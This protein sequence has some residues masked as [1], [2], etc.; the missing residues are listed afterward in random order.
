MIVYPI[1]FITLLFKGM[2]NGRS[3][4]SEVGREVK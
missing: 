1:V 2:K 4:M 3:K